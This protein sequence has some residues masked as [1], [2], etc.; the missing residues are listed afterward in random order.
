MSKR[1]SFFGTLFIILSV[2]A[3]FIGFIYAKNCYHQWKH[4]RAVISWKGTAYE[5]TNKVYNN[6]T[7]VVN[8]EE[9]VELEGILLNITTTQGATTVYFTSGL[10]TDSSYLVGQQPDWLTV[11][12][13]TELTACDSLILM[14]GKQYNLQAAP[15]QVVFSGDVVN[16]DSD[17]LLNFSYF[18]DCRYTQ[19]KTHLYRLHDFC[20]QKVK[21]RARIK[22]AQL[23]KEVLAVELDEAMVLSMEKNKLKFQ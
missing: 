2:V 15:L 13:Q 23:I 8:P 7:F 5:W 21:V 17:K 12:N 11:K 18:E 14:Y 9:Y 1:Q 10:Q 6:S 19:G 20:A 4:D 22:K 3:I 16:S